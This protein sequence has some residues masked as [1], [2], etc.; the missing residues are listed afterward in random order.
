MSNK[1]NI[2]VTG[3]AGYW[4]G[5][6]ATQLAKR[7]DW[8]ILGLD[9]RPPEKEIPDLDFIQADIRNPLV[10]E[11]LREEKVDAVCHLAFV[12]ATRPSEASFDLNVIGTMKILGACAEAGL[13]EVVLKSST[14]VYGAQPM[15]STYLDEEQPLNGTKSYGYVRDLV[16]VEAFV[17]GFQRQ[18]PGIRITSLRFAH[19]VGPKA[20]TPLARFLREEEAFVLL[21]FDPLMQVIHEADAVSAMVHAIDRPAPGVFNVAAEGVLPLWK[22]MGLAGKV[23]A[24]IF[25]PIAYLAVSLLGPRYAPVDL[26]YLRYPCVGDLSKMRESLGFAPQ[27]TAE[28]ALREFAGQQR[29]NKYLPESMARALDEERLR[30]TIERRRRAREHEAQNARWARAEKR[31]Q[32]RKRAVRRTK[33]RLRVTD[34]EQEKGNHG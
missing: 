11:L 21:G 25:H 4:G 19:I 20:D 34:A 26:D 14:M 18:N 7:P 3:V 1:R 24:P 9:D 28:E 8:H 29:L 16:E 10:G 2:L 5:R 30:G 15:N 12:E 27:Y 22:L 31:R 32:A 33:P 23:P 17:N 6:I 13:H